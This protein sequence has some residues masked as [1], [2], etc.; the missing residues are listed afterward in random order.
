MSMMYIE[1]D[2]NMVD[3]QNI[4]QAKKPKIIEA[5]KE[6]K[7]ETPKPETKTTKKKA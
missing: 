7:V 5:V 3:T 2:G 6:V 4:L 1:V